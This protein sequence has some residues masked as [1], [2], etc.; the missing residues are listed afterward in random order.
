MT[1]RKSD[2]ELPEDNCLEE[3]RIRYYRSFYG[4]WDESNDHLFTA[5]AA[6]KAFKVVTEE[7]KGD[8]DEV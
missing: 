4:F 1:K 7:I 5:K 6:I 8:K 3:E 2:A